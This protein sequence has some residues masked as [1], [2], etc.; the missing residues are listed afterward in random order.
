MTLICGKMA[1]KAFLCPFDHVRV[2]KRTRGAT[3]N[4]QPATGNLAGRS[5][6]PEATDATEEL[7]AL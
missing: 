1:V 5:R 6:P 3:G 7:K 4:R 2:I